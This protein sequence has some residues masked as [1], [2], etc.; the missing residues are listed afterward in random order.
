MQPANDRRVETLLPEGFRGVQKRVLRRESEKK[1][2]RL[3]EFGLLS[4]RDWKTTR[5]FI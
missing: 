5:S 2:I 1:S 4:R 3:T